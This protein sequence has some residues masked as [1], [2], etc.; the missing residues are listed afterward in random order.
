MKKFFIVSGL[1][2]TLFSAQYAKAEDQLEE[3]RFNTAFVAAEGAAGMRTDFQQFGISIASE[4]AGVKSTPALGETYMLD[5]K[6]WRF[7]RETAFHRLRRLRLGA[8]V[9]VGKRGK[10]RTFQA[11][12]TFD[13]LLIDKSP[14]ICLFDEPSKRAPFTPAA[15]CLVDRNK[16]GAF[17]SW[18][19]RRSGAQETKQEGEIETAPYESESYLAEMFFRDGNTP[20]PGISVFT[21]GWNEQAMKLRGSWLVPAEDTRELMKAG[22]IDAV[23]AQQQK[24][25]LFNL[26]VLFT[27]NEAPMDIFGMKV[28]ILDAKWETLTYRIENGFGDWWREGSDAALVGDD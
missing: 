16:D 14:A 22:G 1:A 4:A 23:L 9:H 19:S 13:M 11:D 8:D 24:I 12:D 5:G 2:I 7:Y 6:T 26:T 28:S 3:Y 15:N 27:S 21:E 10:A 18:V 17:D 20:L 25:G